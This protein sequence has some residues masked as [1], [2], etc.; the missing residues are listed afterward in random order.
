MDGLHAFFKLMGRDRAAMSARGAPA[1]R[2]GFALSLCAVR[3]NP[4]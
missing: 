4:L 2:L 1:N 3:D